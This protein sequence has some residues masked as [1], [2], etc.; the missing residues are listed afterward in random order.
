MRWLFL[1]AFA[2]VTVVSPLG[3]AAAAALDTTPPTIAAVVTPPP[4][5]AGWNRSKVTVKF[6]CA[7]TE[8]GLKSCPTAIVVTTEGAGQ[9]ITG[10]AVDKAGNTASASLTLNIDR[11]PPVLTAER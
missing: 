8:S 10:T 9:V 1:C 6:V 3:A 7:D 4:N 11:T 2:L 5:A